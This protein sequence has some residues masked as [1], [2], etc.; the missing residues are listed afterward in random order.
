MHTA[1]ISASAP[2]VG[3]CVPHGAPDQIARINVTACVVGSVFATY[4]SHRGN[5]STEKNTPES[6]SITY[7]NAAPSACANRAE[8]TRLATT[9]PSER[10]LVVPSSTATTKL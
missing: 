10:M 8:R 3:S 5:R 9:K 7:V 1:K 6:A 4:C 2:T